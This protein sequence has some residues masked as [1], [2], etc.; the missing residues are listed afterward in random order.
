MTAELDRQQ[1]EYEAYELWGPYLSERQWGTVREDY[2]ERGD[3]WEHFPFDHAHAR[4]YRWGEDGIGGV[5]DNR[6]RMCLAVG[7]WN[8]R[9]P[10]LKERLFGLTN[11]EGNHGEDVKE[12]YYYLD[13]V[14][15]HSYLKMLYK[16]PQT[17]FPYRQLRE[18]NS[19]DSR[20]KND[21]EFELWDTGIFDED[22]YFDVV[23]EYAKAGPEDILLQV[24]AHNR[25]PDAAPLHI[26]PHLWFRNTWSWE[27]NAPRPQISAAG[28]AYARVEH[29]ELAE[30]RFG[31]CN[32]EQTDAGHA[33]EF[34]SLLFCENSTNMPRLFNAPSPSGAEYFKDG[35]NR[36]VV[37]GERSAVNYERHGSKLAA[38]FTATIPPGESRV[39]RVRLTKG[40]ASQSCGDFDAIFADRREEADAFYDS[41]QDGITDDDQR[42]VQ[43]QALAGMIWTK[44]FYH[45]DVDR[46]LDGDPTQV[47]PP[48]N[49]HNG[50]NIDWRHLHNA[51][52]ISMPDKWEYPWYAAWDL[53]FHCL[54]LAKIDP[55]F[56]KRQLKLFTLERYMH[57]T[58]SCPRMSG[59]SPTST[60]RSTP[61]RRG[62]PSSLTGRTTAT[63]TVTFRSWSRCITSC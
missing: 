25:G 60:R 24:T 30:Y 37:H 39:V 48:Q 63:A 13:A 8:E 36:Y 28:D 12:V 16:Y 18:Q 40:T 32:K 57:P 20:G 27:D 5:S 29:P 3:A 19:F 59:S 21:P 34:Q 22:R 14:P 55:E 9:D 62:G 38:H 10:V 35:V 56:A 45:F 7:L 43:R 41:V 53:A 33:A 50:R 52:V 54:P 1:N 51:D 58:D 31:V 42:N 49:R 46:W 11:E 47:K 4:A 26:L 17:E 6:Q 61:G 15:T 2:S 23:I 44:Q